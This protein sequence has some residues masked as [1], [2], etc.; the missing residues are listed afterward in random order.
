[1]EIKYQIRVLT[2]MNVSE[3]SPKFPI[4]FYIL[5]TEHWWQHQLNLHI[6]AQSLR[7]CRTA[8]LITSLQ[9]KKHINSSYSAQID[10]TLP[11]SAGAAGPRRGSIAQQYLSTYSGKDILALSPTTVFGRRGGAARS[12]IVQQHLSTY[13]GKD[14][15]HYHDSGSPI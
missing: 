13:S 14:V 11:A 5:A 6:Y 15:S 12:S 3:C 4:V 7:M 8:I 10:S 2:K 9:N 1:M